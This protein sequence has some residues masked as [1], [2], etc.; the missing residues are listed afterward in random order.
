MKFFIRV[1][2]RSPHGRMNFSFTIGLAMPDT[3]QCHLLIAYTKDILSLG[4]L[5][6][7]NLSEW[8]GTFYRR[9]ARRYITE[10]MVNSQKSLICLLIH[11]ISYLF[12]GSLFLFFVPPS[13][14]SS[15]FKLFFF[16]LLQPCHKE[17]KKYN[18]QLMEALGIL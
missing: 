15:I 8:I 1:C 13:L 10:I 4:L 12:S 14:G 7:I 6:K 11:R 18:M 5:C 9:G 16:K 3:C 2:L 17:K